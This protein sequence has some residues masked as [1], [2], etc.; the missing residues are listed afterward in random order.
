MDCS[1]WQCVA[2]YCSVLQC[3]AECCSVLQCQC[4]HELHSVAVCCS[5]GALQCIVVYCSAMH[6]SGLQSQYTASVLQ[7]IV[8]CCSVTLNTCVRGTSARYQH[9]TR[10]REHTFV[11]Y[12][13][14]LLCCSNTHRTPY[15][16]PRTQVCVILQHTPRWILFHTVREILQLPTP[17]CN[18]NRVYC[19]TRSCDTATHAWLDSFC[20]YG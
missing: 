3:V 4:A 7:C 19:N 11:W 20:I 9:P 16:F 12:S 14:T 5:V 6:C 1:V 13:K 8:V 18:H 17:L 2:A 15:T 10:F